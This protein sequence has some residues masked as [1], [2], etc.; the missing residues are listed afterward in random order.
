MEIK[1]PLEKK[2]D[3]MKAFLSQEREK[4]LKSID[5]LHKELETIE[6]EYKVLNNIKELYEHKRHIELRKCLFDADEE[7]I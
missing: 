5:K 3:E 7:V 2:I 6:K 4:A 1:Y